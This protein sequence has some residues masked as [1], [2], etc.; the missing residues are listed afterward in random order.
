MR[1][2]P[3]PAAH[4]KDTVV[5]HIDLLLRL[6][7]HAALGSLIPHTELFEYI[8]ATAP[9]VLLTHKVF[10]D[11]VAKK[12]KEFARDMKAGRVTHEPLTR[13]MATLSE[14]IRSADANAA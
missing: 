4:D 9:V 7:E 2:P 10:R 5:K 11:T 1:I 14:M 12:V 8:L 13:V 6:T 3:R